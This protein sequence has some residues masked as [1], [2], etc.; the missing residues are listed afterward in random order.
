[1]SDQQYLS[2]L[3]LADLHLAHQPQFAGTEKVLTDNQ[4]KNIVSILDSTHKEIKQE[5][6]LL[7]EALKITVGPSAIKNDAINTL[8]GM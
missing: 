6:Q 3:H 2:L 1:M 7:T 8:Q 4:Y 5:L